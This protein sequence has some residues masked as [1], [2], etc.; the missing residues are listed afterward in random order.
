MTAV[1]PARLFNPWTKARGIVLAV[2]GGPDSMA[3]LLLAAR[4]AASGQTPPLFAATV[5][6]GLRPQARAEARLV[7]A[8]AG[9]LAI[10]HAT[11][12]W[13]GQKPATALQEKAREARYDL[14]LR[15]A[16]RKGADVLM[17]AHHADD[18]AETVLFRLL[19]GSGV[20][21]LAGI[22]PVTTRAHVTIARPLLDLRK[23]ELIEVCR[24]AGQEFVADPANVDGRY[25]RTDMRALLDA[26]ETRGMGAR[27]WAR[28]A[29]RL[30]RADA[31]LSAA[32]AE[33]AGRARKASVENSGALDLPTLAAAPEEISLRAL[34]F[35]LEAC[36]ARQPI[37]LEKLES[38][39]HRLFRSLS[40][41]MAGAATLAGLR[42]KL[43]RKGVLRAL[44]EGPRRRGARSI[45]PGKAPAPENNLSLS[46]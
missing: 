14:L 29:R 3:L 34:A 33:W 21:G 39:H 16:A 43:D 9:G 8:T 22:R 13:R 2:S 40:G 11:L 25:A 44:P 20:A 26:L 42:L 46:K 1:D 45:R 37:R 38:L 30:A 32:A 7:A 19:R 4:W 36:G 12:A 17:T 41:G 18:Q 31:A 6:H 35:F 10:P 24:A 27:E 28:L 23:G 5:D 15:H